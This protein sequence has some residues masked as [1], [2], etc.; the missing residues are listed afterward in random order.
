MS[1]TQN[2]VLDPFKLGEPEAPSRTVKLFDANEEELDLSDIGS[3]RQKAF[4]H[5]YFD[6]VSDWLGQHGPALAHLLLILGSAA[7][8]VTNSRH[9]ATIEGQLVF[10]MFATLL[11]CGLIIEAAFAYAWMKKGSTDLAGTQLHEARKLYNLSSVIMI[12][13]LSLSVAAVAIGAGQIAEYWVGIIQPIGAVFLIRFFYNL[14]GAHP[15]T[16]ARQRVV[17]LKAYQE[18]ALVEDEAEALQLVLDE[19]RHE[20]FMKR[21]ALEQRIGA[22]E[23]LVNSGWFRRQIK[24]ATK[25]AVGQK[26]LP[27]VV[28]KL[29]KLPELLRLKGRSN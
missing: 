14:K 21:A 28:G 7:G 17:S 16:I 27:E 10:S 6:T 26:L 15:M 8:T 19:K 3:G 24:R 2:G 20:R 23:A 18:A 29:Q 5:S 11:L 9:F 25:E 1:T 4:E 22:G 12:G 13:D